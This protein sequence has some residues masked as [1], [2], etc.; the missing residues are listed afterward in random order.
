[1]VIVQMYCTHS[2]REWDMHFADIG[3]KA[4]PRYWVNGG[5]TRPRGVGENM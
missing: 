5:S 4:A 3:F 1:M 2:W